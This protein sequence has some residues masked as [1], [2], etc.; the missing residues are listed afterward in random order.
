MS[1]PEDD[2]RDDDDNDDVEEYD[3]DPILGGRSE[4]RSIIEGLLRKTVEK[5]IEAGVSTISRA[6]NAIRGVVEDTKVP[7]EVLSYVF[8]QVDESKNALVGAV[9]GEVREFLDQT[10]LAAE[11][12]RALTSLSFEVKTEIRFI[13]NEAGDMKPRVKAKVA[14]KRSPRRRR[15]ARDKA[16]DASETAAEAPAAP[17]SDEESARPSA[18]APKAPKPASEP[19]PPSAPE[20][21][22]ANEGE[23]NDES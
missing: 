8:S 5:G 20:H 14:P 10:D 23:N 9:A 18:R 19:A 21:E 13:P 1:H 11:L 7:R 12:R 22:S 15:R 4:S 3:D 2:F 17:P 16:D 6:D